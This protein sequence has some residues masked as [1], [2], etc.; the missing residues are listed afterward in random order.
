MSGLLVPTSTGSFRICRPTCTVLCSRACPLCATGTLLS[1]S[2]EV[3]T[4]VTTTVFSLRYG[5]CHKYFYTVALTFVLQ[6][7]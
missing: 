2:T 7:F 1:L 6:V 5:L 3:G 4:S